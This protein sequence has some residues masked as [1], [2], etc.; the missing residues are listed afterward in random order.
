MIFIPL[1][2]KPLKFND[3]VTFTFPRNMCCNCGTSTELAMV[4]QDTRCS[5]SGMGTLTEFTFGL[6]LPFCAS[7][8]PSAKRRPVRGAERALVAFGVFGGVAASFLLLPPA[9]QESSTVQQCIL[10]V[11]GVVAAA[12]TV[13]WVAL[14]R[15][16]G[17]QSSYFQPVRLLAVKGEFISGS[18]KLIRFAFTNSSYRN[19][20]ESDNA[21][22]INRKA[23]QAKAA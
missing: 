14:T 23:V 20:F 8:A 1:G 4:D 21:D 22:A 5:S 7:C 6:T 11:A 10:P 15:P 16:R 9:L 18:V 17:E 13:A 12:V 3:G 19:A 2:K